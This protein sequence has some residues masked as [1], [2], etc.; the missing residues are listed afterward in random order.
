MRSAWQFEVGRTTQC[1]IRL[2]MRFLAK[3]NTQKMLDLCFNIPSLAC[4]RWSLHP[5][6]R[7]G[8]HADHTRRWCYHLHLLGTEF[9]FLSTGSIMQ[10]GKLFGLEHRRQWR[11]AALENPSKPVNKI[12]VQA[13]VSPLLFHRGHTSRHFCNTRNCS[14]GK[15]RTAA[16]LH[17]KKCNPYGCS[18][19]QYPIHTPVLF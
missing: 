3:E 2:G 8:V 6:T 5:T 16:I 10:N 15:Y 11:G 17:R 9:I 4:I 13:K 7:P 18:Q 1:K 14:S 12:E 19:N